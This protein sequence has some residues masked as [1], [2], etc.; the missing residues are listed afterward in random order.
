MVW[1]IHAG[2]TVP[3]GR[4]CS[5]TKRPSHLSKQKGR[6]AARRAPDEPR[7]YVDL[8]RHEDR[9]IIYV[10]DTRELSEALDTHT[11]Q[12]S[13]PNT[14]VTRTVY[15]GDVARGL[16]PGLSIK[17]RS[18]ERERLPGLLFIDQRY[19]TMIT[20]ATGKKPSA[21]PTAV[22]FCTAGFT[23]ERRPLTRPKRCQST[24]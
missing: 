2:L 24:P 14:P 10:R 5:L 20:A 1:F 22:I 8:V 23:A 19:I 21:R 4:A 9:F 7:R 18:Y 13:F 15:F 3:G 11:R 12:L 17:G 6:S 16:P